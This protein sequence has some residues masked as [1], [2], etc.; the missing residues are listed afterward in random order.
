MA[1]ACSDCRKIG[2]SGT[3]CKDLQS[4]LRQSTHHNY[5]DGFGI[6]QQS[7]RSTHIEA[8]IALLN[9]ILLHCLSS[10][11]WD[12]LRPAYQYFSMFPN[13]INDI[14]RFLLLS[15]PAAFLLAPPVQPRVI[16][17]G[18]FASHGLVRSCPRSPGPK[19]LHFC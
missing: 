1:S 17:A 19:G 14:A 2:E 15:Q 12:D 4:R 3:C 13:H 7:A 16:A 6:G 5:L 8:A 10:E 18:L 11:H 9:N